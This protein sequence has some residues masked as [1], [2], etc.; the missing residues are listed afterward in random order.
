MSCLAQRALDLLGIFVVSLVN[1]AQ[2]KVRLALRKLDAAYQVPEA[3][4]LLHESILRSLKMS[5]SRIHAY[6][7]LPAWVVK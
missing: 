3:L 2:D 1:L 7:S 5:H 6:F 4:V